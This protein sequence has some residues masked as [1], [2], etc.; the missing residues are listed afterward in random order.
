VNSG[1]SCF[2]ILGFREFHLFGV[3]CGRRVDRSHHAGGSIY[4][5]IGLAEDHFKYPV[6]AR[7]NFG[8]E[9]ETSWVLDLSRMM[10]TQLIRNRVI[11]V[12]NCSDGALIEDTVPRLPESVDLASPPLDRER[13]LAEIERRMVPFDGNAVVRAADLPQ[14]SADAWALVDMLEEILLDCADADEPFSEVFARLHLR[15]ARAQIEQA[16]AYATMGGSIRALA[17]VGM[18]FGTRMAGEEM[19]RRLFLLYSDEFRR[20]ARHM[21]REVEKLVESVEARMS[22]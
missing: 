7:A 10:L 17:R 3:D 14:F 9:A 4:H 18:Y 6:P 20:V 5:E 16:G 12:F 8:G 19:S 15:L 21:A 22:T 1:L 2:S 11:T 13:L